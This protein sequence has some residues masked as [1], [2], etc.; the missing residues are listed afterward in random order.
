MSVAATPKYKQGAYWSNESSDQKYFDH[1]V[2]Y[3]GYNVTD[4]P[5]SAIKAAEGV[6]GLVPETVFTITFPTMPE[7]ALCKHLYKLQS[8]IFGIKGQLQDTK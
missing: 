1:H 7:S 5:Y 4:V 2:F 8:I 3:V 6:W